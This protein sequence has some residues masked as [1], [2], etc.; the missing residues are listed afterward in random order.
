LGAAG[1]RD[2]PHSQSFSTSQPTPDSRSEIGIPRH[3]S[4][5]EILH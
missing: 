3:P 1:L 2:S 4:S 5:P